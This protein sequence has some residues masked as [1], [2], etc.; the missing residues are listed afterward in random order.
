MLSTYLTR[1]LFASV[2]L[3]ALIIPVTMH[4]EPIDFSQVDPADHTYEDWYL[5]SVEGQPAGYW[6][7]SLT[8]KDGR[9]VSV[10]DEYSV[11][12]HGG[13]QSTYTYRVVWTETT[14]FKPIQVVVTSAA[15]SDE[16][17][18]TYRFVDDGIE[19]TSEQ[20]GRSIQRKLPPIQGKFLT[21]AQAS[22]ATDLYLQRGD[23]SFEFMT[24]DFNVGLTPFRNMYKR[25]AE[26][27][28]VKL[29]DGKEAK[30]QVWSATY[31]VFPGFETEYWINELS[32]IVGLSYEVDG[33]KFDSRLAD[34]S[35]A[36]MAF[37][38]PEMSGLSVVVPDRPIDHVNRQRR[39][40]YELHYKSGDSNIVPVTTAQQA[41]KPM[42]KG[43][44]RVT[45]DLDA[46][47]GSPKSDR[48]G[49]EHLANSIMVDHKDEVVSKL[50]KRAVAGL[51]ADV[52]TT[53]IAT[54]CKRYVTR[55]LT[56][57]SLSVGD[58]SASQAARTREGDC[59]EASVLL[60]ALLRAN[61]IP[62]RCV[63][64]LVYSEDEFVGQEDVFVYHMWTQAWIGGE[65]GK[66][67]W[68]DLDSAMWRYSAG[69]IALGVSAMGDEDQ[70]DL[71]EIVPLQQDLEI[72][73][74][75]TCVE[76]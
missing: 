24:L 12:S 71:A 66:G 56:G 14:D 20:N 67:Y 61:G 58:G 52:D 63:N 72:K 69:H 48:P 26:K 76:D 37:D 46:K 75:E 39:I 33:V 43:K 34:A 38:P 59:T 36:E 53:T 19:L 49:P 31:S 8:V 22:I 25:Q 1:F 18:K 27:T 15:G 40:V 17:Q 51:D 65:D 50:A 10:Y 54:T 41:V 70:Q 2:V 5:D 55:H 3:L 30:A 7:A 64:G 60:A 45:V 28:T 9:L 29:A 62:S 16:V 11:E 42:G 32:E 47:P 13:E 35:V 44:A 4:A 74:I 23:D 21:A 73:V 57:V 6:H 68:L